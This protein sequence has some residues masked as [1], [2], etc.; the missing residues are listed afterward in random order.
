M[1]APL[2]GA[3]RTRGL[4]VEPSLS[5]GR[6]HLIVGKEHHIG[7]LLQKRGSTRMQLHLIA[8]VGIVL[9]AFKALDIGV[10]DLHNRHPKVITQ[11]VQ[12]LNVLAP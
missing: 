2:A 11:G 5:L 3:D 7:V 1:H 6:C 9:R 8:I 12:S 10:A 4:L